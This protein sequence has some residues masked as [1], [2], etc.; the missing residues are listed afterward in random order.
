MR[1]AKNTHL[2]IKRFIF[3][4]EDI[5]FKKKRKHTQRNVEMKK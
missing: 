3:S 1:G 5:G 4:S 2:S